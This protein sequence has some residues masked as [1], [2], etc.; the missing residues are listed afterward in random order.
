M[1]GRRSFHEQ[2]VEAS[3]ERHRRLSLLDEEIAADA[4]RK[5]RSSSASH[6][7]ERGATSRNARPPAA[8][9]NWQRVRQVAENFEETVDGGL[10]RRP[11]STSSRSDTE[12]AD[13]SS[14]RSS[15]NDDNLVAF[16]GHDEE[17]REQLKKSRDERRASLEPSPLSNAEFV[18]SSAGPTPRRSQGAAQDEQQSAAAGDNS[19]SKIKRRLV[20]LEQDLLDANEAV[21]QI[22]TTL[23][24]EREQHDSALTN[25]TK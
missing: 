2:F 13:L 20:Q 7:S 21:R 16:F 14:R 9:V 15:F 5:E 19:D 18:S 17:L 3:K 23:Q 24:S 22:T 1:D 25:Q 8:T 12:R 6:D 11:S 10:R 4:C